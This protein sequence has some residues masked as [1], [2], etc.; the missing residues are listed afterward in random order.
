MVFVTLFSLFY[1]P[2]DGIPF[3]TIP[4]LDKIVH[5][6]FYFGAAISASLCF[7]E[8]TGG[9]KNLKK[10]LLLTAVLSIIYGIIIEVLQETLTTYR[11]GNLYDAIANAIGALFGII[12]LWYI[13]SVQRRFKWKV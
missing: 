11:D 13:F 1:F 7:R 5:F 9:R 6:T 12:V 8:Q 10:V 3:F 2:D 4:H